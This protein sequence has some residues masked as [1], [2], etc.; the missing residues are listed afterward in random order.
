[1][2]TIS[3]SYSAAGAGAAKASPAE[4]CTMVVE[5]QRA[6]VCRGVEERKEDEDLGWCWANREL[7]SGAALGPALATR[8][9]VDA[10]AKLRE[11][12]KLMSGGC[13]G[14]EGDC[15]AVKTTQF[16]NS[17]WLWEERLRDGIRSKCRRAMMVTP[18]GNLR[19]WGHSWWGM[20]TEVRLDHLVVFAESAHLCAML[21]S[22][23]PKTCLYHSDIALSVKDEY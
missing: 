4:A 13:E 8:L 12:M 5:K 23:K 1:M 10:R 2:S 21:A 16:Y 22:S 15:I 3:W 17:Q 7:Q 9:R 20:E 11:A 14:G 18:S 19:L 6:E